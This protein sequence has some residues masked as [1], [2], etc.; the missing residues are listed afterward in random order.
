MALANQGIP[1]SN[2]V[3]EAGVTWLQNQ[4]CSDGGW[5]AYRS[6]VTTACPAPDPST[7]SGPDTN[8]TALA[9]EGLVASGASFP[10]DPLPFFEAAQDPDGGFGFIGISSPSTT[11]PSD[12]D[13]TGEVIQALVALKQ[14][15]NAAFTK[16][17]DPGTATPVTALATFQ[18]GCAAAAGDRGAYTFPGAGS[19]PNLLATLQAVPGAAEVAF[20]LKDVTV[21][22]SLPKLKCPAH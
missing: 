4:Q 10:V 5:E 1:N 8:S 22:G 12:P 16:N 21:K 18:L 20:P 11:Q 7:F 15:S 6:D 3:V 17:L 14:L 19:G 9:V 2:A 13:S